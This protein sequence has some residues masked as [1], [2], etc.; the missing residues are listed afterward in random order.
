MLAYT[1]C[2]RL[3]GLLVLI[4]TPSSVLAADS[5][6][7]ALEARAI[8]S[9]RC[10]ACHGP[11]AAE[12]QGGF[13]LDARES[14]LGEADSG[15]LPIVPG[16]PDRSEALRR[17]LSA[18]DSERMPPADFGSGLTP[19]ETDI[20]RQ[21]IADGA[22]LPEHWSFVP[23]KRPSLPL[24]SQHATSDHE[25]SWTESAIDRFV[26]VEQEKHGLA[27][28]PRAGRGELLRRLSLDLI[29][30]P[31]TVDQ[32]DAFEQDP[33]PGAYQRQVER[34][35][36]SPA[37]GEHWARKWLDLARYADSAGYADDPPRTIW[38]YRDW[39]I[40]AL[41][42]NMSIEE[43]TVKQ[44]AGD[45]LDHPT[46]ADLVA[47]AFHRNT[48]TN[49]EGGTND[50]E[51]RNAA[52]VDRVNTTMAVW[53]G[54]TMACAQCH[55]HKY[56]PFLHDEYFQ[57]FAIFNQTAD[58]DRRD[59]KPVIE[60]F[61]RDQLFAREAW[62][63]RLEEIDR[64]LHQVPKVVHS[65][66]K[67]W[68]EEWTEP[69]WTTLRPLAFDSQ[70]GA[71]AR[72]LDG[73]I[74]SAQLAEGQATDAEK[75][76]VY[77]V[78]LQLPS[79]W[80]GQTLRSLQLAVLPDPLRD[81]AVGLTKH[82]NFVVTK[83]SASLLPGNT[84]DRV[85][86]AE[87]GTLLPSARSIAAATSRVPARFVR[88]ELPG[89]S[90]LLSLAELQVWSF[91]K[92]IALQGTASQSSTDYA[93]D[94]SRAIDGDTDGDY[95]QNSTTH[96]KTSDAPWWEVDLGSPQAIDRVVVWNR[97]DSN[98][99]SRLNGAVI[100]L[101]DESR[102]VLTRET[103][104]EA[105]QLSQELVFERSTPLAFSR[106]TAD[107]EQTDFPASAVIDG[108]GKSGWGIG[109]RSQ[110]EHAL[111]LLLDRPLSIT[112]PGRLRI[113][114][115]QESGYGQHQLGRFRV[116]ASIDPA[117]DRWTAVPENL[118]YIVKQ[119][120][121][122]RSLED[123][124][125][126][127]LFFNQNL[128]AATESLRAERLELELQ[129][130]ELKPE[131]SVPV[132]RAVPGADSRETFVQIRGNYKSLGNRVEPGTPA[133]FHPLPDSTGPPDRL[134]LAKWLVDR[135]N[136]LTA[137]VWANRLWESLFGLGIVRSSEEFGAQGDAPTHPQLLDWLAVE[138]MDN[139]WDQKDLLRQ[140]VS[141]Q[142]YQQTSR[143]T[144][145]V[146][147][148]DKDNEWLARG[149]RVRLSAEMVRDQSLQLADLLSQ[150]MYGP[151]VRP[152]QPNL[153]LKAAFG[154]DTDWQTSDGG[155]RYRRGLYTTWR[156]S[157]PYPSMAT[158]DAPSR[159]VCTL[160]RDSTNTPLQALVTL[161]DP[162]FVEAA[163]SLAR[164]VVLAAGDGH[165]AVPESER[166]EEGDSDSRRLARVFRRCTSRTITDR[167]S[168]VLL[169]LLTDARAGLVQDQTAAEKLATDPLG[170]APDGAD[171]VELAAWT[172]VCNVL[173]NLDEVLMKR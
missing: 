22:E 149:P 83:I 40:D 128:A 53:M 4:L 164:Q 15:E 84:L 101:L 165:A 9:N 5:S 134:A 114:I 12:R 21:W 172:A 62:D 76:D 77:S 79:A 13:R 80:V 47:T 155:D 108:S 6:Q 146:L 110:A 41:N 11:D 113:E 70:A 18:E 32:I 138:L 81:G 133:I 3:L 10:F 61:T 135:R 56:D 37:Y 118:R 50:E 82:G 94:A 126:W 19:V 16:E 2:R 88:V 141:S 173:L 63:A 137:R 142:T 93:G 106:A 129:L 97:T 57:L 29:G 69:H 39:V 35:L 96:T 143:V 124:Q 107:Y 90:R 151:P 31:P 17:M 85:R 136:P 98:L 115:R 150:Q 20:I 123:Q 65:E 158:F 25:H 163:Q 86:E 147:L 89:K 104:R 156:R 48:M 28:S 144:P 24:A 30:L 100:S 119:P 122:Q 121:A 132:Q 7:I 166:Y 49:S 23:P 87:L 102:Q 91:D 72:E 38:A 168:H 8:L 161:N 160:R 130:K 112:E 43:F 64:Q 26:L 169:A 36:A 55:T 140:I 159:E 167:E 109:G 71:A 125:A 68:E 33:L 103:L 127:S 52:I 1:S 34:L 120:S 60:L 44:L 171:V 46:Q 51:F 117:V 148:Q 95:N 139:G 42:G 67:Q 58:A 54:V 116:A 45:L 66:M 14:Y 99:Q 74:L 170:P 105:P 145:Q 153:G 59:E 73:N 111:T 154:G 157:N 131:T 27:P 162:A 78:E 152:P 92:N 75:G